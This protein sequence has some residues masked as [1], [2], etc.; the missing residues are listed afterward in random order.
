LHPSNWLLIDASAALNGLAQMLTVRSEILASAAEVAADK[1]AVDAALALL[2]VSALQTIGGTPVTITDYDN[3]KNFPNTVIYAAA[4]ASLLVNGFEYGVVG[5][6]GRAGLGFYYALDANNGYIQLVAIGSGNRWY[7][8]YEGGVWLPWSKL[9]NFNEVVRRDF[10]L[11]GNAEG[12]VDGATTAGADIYKIAGGSSNL[13]S[14]AS[15]GDI[16]LAMN[17]STAEGS[18]LI[19]GRNG[20]IA[21]K[22]KTGN[23]W[24][25]WIE[26]LVPTEIT[27][28]GLTLSGNAN[29]L[30]GGGNIIGGDI[31]RVV[32]GFSNLPTWAAVDDV[33]INMPAT[34]TDGAQIC[35]SQTGVGAI[36]G[37]NG[38][39]WTSWTDIQN[40]L[41][42][43]SAQIAYAND[44]SGSVAHGLGAVPRQV[45]AYLICLTAQGG[46]AVGDRLRI[47]PAFVQVKA[48]AT[49]ISYRVLNT[50][51]ASMNAGGTATSLTPANFRL[52]LQAD[53]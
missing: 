49:N 37:F 52:V 34:A 20:K 43:E 45:D 42:F 21:T 40:P 11:T 44:G 15:V 31:Y 23:V 13:P 26:Y 24:G 36:R 1:A 27:R 35:L 5:S 10:Q 47:N 51:I 9:P 16:M 30:M 8:R 53:L 2:S 7:R 29:S 32:A 25:A 38:G 4:P 19:I 39:V 6:P 22:G 3:A 33:L 46:I 50:G 14:W 48:D 41:R 17:T 18:L 28:K 12:A